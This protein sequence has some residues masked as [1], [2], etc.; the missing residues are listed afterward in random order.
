MNSVNL[1]GR[2]TQ[3]PEARTSKSGETKYTTFGLAVNDRYGDKDRATFVNVTAFGKLG[4][5]L[6]AHKHKGD[7]IAVT[8]R[9]TTSEGFK[10][11]RV[12]ADRVEFLA[13]ANGNG[14]GTQTPAAEETEEIPL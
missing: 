14:K 4:E 3:D 13:R 8:G 11:L 9:L 5:I 12:V 1:V 7:Q 10:D 2:L 6:A